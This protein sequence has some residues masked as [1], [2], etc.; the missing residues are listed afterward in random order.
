MFDHVSFEV[1][2]YAAS[3]A[4]YLRALEPLGIVLLTEEPWKARDLLCGQT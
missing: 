4:F 3:K 2:D 1:S